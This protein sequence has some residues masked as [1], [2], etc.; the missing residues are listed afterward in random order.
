M[1]VLK[2]S[3][4]VFVNLGDKFQAKSLLLLPQRFA[5]GCTDRGWIVR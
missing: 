5:I 4:S 3:G 1:R 2:P